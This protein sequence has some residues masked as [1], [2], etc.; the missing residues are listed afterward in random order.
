MG[1]HKVNILMLDSDHQMDLDFCSSVAD[2]IIYFYED[3]PLKDCPNIIY[4]YQSMEEIIKR[5]LQVQMKGLPE[6]VPLG[7]GTKIITIYGPAYYMSQMAFSIGLA[8]AYEKKYPTL[9]LN[10]HPYLDLSYFTNQSNNKSLSDVF[11]Y[12]RQN[13]SNL[14]QKIESTVNSNQ[15]LNYINSMDH[16]QDVCDFTKEELLRLLEVFQQ[17]DRFKVIVIEVTG[18]FQG[19][20][21]LLNNSDLIIIPQYTL[22]WA[23][24]K[25]AMLYQQL[26]SYHYMDFTGR[27][28]EVELDPYTYENEVFQLKDLQV[29]TKDLVRPFINF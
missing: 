22:L 25:K 19:L 8:M 24:R 10:F 27:I 2:H 18:S 12:L 20:P 4:K 7:K 1:D 26:N 28:Q 5:L 6:E 15:Y 23:Q 21:H 16:S 17:Q 29:A 9:Y 14:F 11:Y 13:N 3:E